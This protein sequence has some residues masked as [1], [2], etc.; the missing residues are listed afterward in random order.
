VARVPPTKR[1]IGQRPER[2]QV[3]VRRVDGRSFAEQACAVLVDR[4]AREQLREAARIRDDAEQEHARGVVGIPHR[5]AQ[6]LGADAEPRHRPAG[7]RDARGHTLLGDTQILVV[8][9]LE[10]VRHRGGATTSK[11]DLLTHVSIA[12]GDAALSTRQAEATLYPCRKPARRIRRVH[13][14]RRARLRVPRR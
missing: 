8:D 6:R 11:G 5:V 7:H 12:R 13:R 9:G 10:R 3:H 4:E 1:S 14:R 2:I